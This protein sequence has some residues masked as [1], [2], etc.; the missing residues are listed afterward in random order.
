MS[1]HHLRPQPANCRRQTRSLTLSASGSWISLN[2]EIEFGAE[3]LLT[4]SALTTTSKAGL[5]LEPMGGPSADYEVKSTRFATIERKLAQVDC[6]VVELVEGN[7][8]RTQVTWLLRKQNMGWR[9]AGLLVSVQPGDPHDLL[10][11]ENSSD[12]E[13][14]KS[15]AASES[16]G[17]LD[18]RQAAAPSDAGELK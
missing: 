4:R 9:V 2:R 15:L 3:N 10:S 13:R 16:F 17:D 8:V 1:Q 12:V 18:T 11:F 14:I 7:E 5:Q 6:D